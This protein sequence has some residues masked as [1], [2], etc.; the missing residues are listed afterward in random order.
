MLE[1]IVVS[2]KFLT[3][4]LDMAE[5][6]NDITEI[7]PYLRLIVEDTI[8]LTHRRHSAARSVRQDSW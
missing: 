3:R 1:R 2:L 6:V 7:I 8:T 4:L 5:L